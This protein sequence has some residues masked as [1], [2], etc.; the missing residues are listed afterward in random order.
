MF[1]GGSL[2]VDSGSVDS[3]S[4]GSSNAVTPT[5]ARSPTQWTSRPV[6]EWDAQQVGNATFFFNADTH[7]QF[8]RYVPVIR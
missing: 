1:V 8:K 2:E 6:G 4:V 7:L 5:S 3:R